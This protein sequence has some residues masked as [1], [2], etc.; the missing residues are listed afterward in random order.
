MKPLIVPFVLLLLTHLATAQPVFTY[1]G[2]P[3]SRQEFLQAFHKNPDTTLPRKQALLE[4]LNLYIAYKL[5]VKAARDAG[6]S[7]QPDIL[8]QAE[9]FR[10]QL[11]N[12]AI[13]QEA[14]IEYLTREALIRSQTDILVEQWYLPGTGGEAM[15]KAAELSAAIKN[16]KAAPPP[17]PLGW[18]T[19]F[20][21]PYEAENLVYQ[22]P[23]GIVAAPYKTGE[24]IYLLRPVQ[25]RAAMGTV[26]INQLLVPV[27]ATFSEEE[28]RLAGAKAGDIYT[29]L[30]RGASMDTAGAALYLSPQELSVKVGQYDPAFEEKIFQGKKGALLT[31]VRTGYGWHLIRILDRIPVPA[32]TSPGGEAYAQMKTL[33]EQDGRMNQAISLLTR[34]WMKMSGY[35]EKNFNREEAKAYLD[36]FKSNKS[37]N[38]NI[39][40]VN[41]QTILFSFQKQ[42][43]TLGDFSRYAAAVRDAGMELQYAP[44]DKQLEAYKE[45][46]VSEYYRNHLVD[47][48][49]AL[50]AQLQ[51]FNDANML[52]AIMEKEVWNKAGNDS[53]GLAR[54]YEEHRAGYWWSPS[55]SILSLSSRDRSLI[56]KAAVELQADA[57][58]W[59]SLNTQYEGSLFADSSRLEMTQLPTLESIKPGSHTPVTQMINMDD[60][61]YSYVQVVSV[62]PDKEPKSFADARGQV[63]TKYQQELEKRWLDALRRKYPVVINEQVFSRL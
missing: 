59:R 49:P 27:P 47:M 24:G 50:A 33:T 31:P 38:R 20:T 44:L 37:F 10:R 39:G 13:Q 12:R 42:N 1:G 30:Q 32:D 3:V 53:A 61:V 52:F 60:T 29:Q 43:A 57:S 63:V 48:K 7:Q 54:Y 9:S 21:L 8:Q 6:Y 22:T 14:N 41:S 40:A 55:V 28:A 35:Q 36:S 56:E 62:H 45:V 19:V 15:K 4:Y 2:T 26:R 23:I 5:K 58:R 11:T 16:G 51:E 17:A 25:K 46:A 34:H 18:I